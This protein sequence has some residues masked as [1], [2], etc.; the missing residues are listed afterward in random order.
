VS[1]L[2]GSLGV[3][4]GS[5]ERFVAARAV[6]EVATQW[7]PVRVKAGAGRLRPEHEDVARIARET[8]R[9]YADIARQVTDAA[10]DRLESDGE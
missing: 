6:I 3:R 4:I 5:V 7:G 9:S 10:Q 8:G 2:T 1:E